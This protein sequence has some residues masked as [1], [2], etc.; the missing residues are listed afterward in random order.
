MSCFESFLFWKPAESLELYLASTSKISSERV[1]LIF[2][3]YTLSPFV[4]R[5][6]N[7]E[8]NLPDALFG[9]QRQRKYS[10]GF[11]TF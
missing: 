3:V 8:P 9:E 4:R 10:M 11:R 5:A 7:N 6:A 2:I 1:V